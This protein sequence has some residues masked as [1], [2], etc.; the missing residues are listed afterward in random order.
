M[1]DSLGSHN[2][3]KPR[4]GLNLLSTRSRNVPTPTAG[5][6]IT[7]SPEGVGHKHNVQHV[8]LLL[9]LTPNILS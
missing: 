4:P 5:P 6:S 8:S 3:D 9:H 2:H 1:V 7:C